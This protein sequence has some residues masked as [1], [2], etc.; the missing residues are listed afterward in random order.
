MTDASESQRMLAPWEKGWTPELVQG[1]PIPPK[2]PKPPKSSVPI[3]DKQGPDGRFLPGV[4][5]NPK[6]RPPGPSPQAKLLRRMLDE[7]DD[8]LTAI[9]A[10]AK[11]GDAA[12]AQIVLSRVTPVLKAAAEKVQFDFRTDVPLSEQAEAVMAAVASGAVDPE[13]G[14]LLIGCLQSVS[15]IRAVEDL[16]QRII[17]LEAKQI[18]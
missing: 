15:G 7:S 2:P 8:I 13:T 12:S 6:G 1:V 3:S 10:K 14:K 11:E 9:L 18:G 4:S 16:E 5:G 17:Q